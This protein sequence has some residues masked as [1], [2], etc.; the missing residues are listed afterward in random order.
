LSGDW[1]IL[2]VGELFWGDP[3]AAGEESVYMKKINRFLY[4]QGVCYGRSPVFH[5]IICNLNYFLN[6]YFYI[7]TKYVHIFIV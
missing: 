1:S 3:A 4:E 2:V 5:N 7:K 6:L